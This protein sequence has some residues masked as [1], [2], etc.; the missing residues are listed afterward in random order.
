MSETMNSV[1]TKYIY[2]YEKW[3]DFTWDDKQISVILGKVRHFQGK[4][5]GQ[6]DALGFSMKEETM[7]STLTLDVLKS[8][9]IEGEF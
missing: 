1:M 3:P 9:E 7:L 4:I 5:F 2:E 8:S 6:M